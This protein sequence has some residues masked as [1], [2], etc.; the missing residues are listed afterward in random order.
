MN[1][2]LKIFLA[3]GAS[4][5]TLGLASFLSPAPSVARSVL[6]SAV[7]TGW[8][9]GPSVDGYGTIIHTTDGGATWV[10][11]GSAAQ[12]PDVYLHGVRAIDAHN[13]WVVGDE[14]DGYGVIL[15]TTDGG[16][17]WVRQGSPA[18]IP[19]ADLY[20]VSA[21]DGNTAWV[22]GSEVVG[23]QSVILHTADGGNTW[24]RQG[25]GTVPPGDYGGVM[26]V[27]AQNVWV[28]GATL[29]KTGVIFR[30]TDGGT[31][32]VQQGQ[33]LDELN[34]HWLIS[35]YA[36]DTDTA[37]A[38]GHDTTIHTS[39]SGTT[40]ITQTL[41]GVGEVDVNDVFAVDRNTAW[42][43]TDFGGI[44]FSQNGGTTWT[45]QTVPPGVEG[46]YLIRISAIDAQTAW[47]IG[48]A[49]SFPPDGVV[50]HTEDG[51]NTW[52]E[53][54]TPVT[55]T[56]SGVSFARPGVYFLPLILKNH[57]PA[58][59]LV[60]E[61]IVAEANQVQVVIKNQGDQ[62]V[63]DDEA[64]EFW[65]DLYINP[66]PVPDRVNQTWPYVAD[67]GAAWGITWSGSPYT[68]ADPARQ[69][70]PLEPGEVFTLTTEGDYWWQPGD[71]ISWPLTLGNAVYAQVDSAGASYG[72]VLENHEITG[73]PYNNVS[74]E[75]NVAGLGSGAA[76][77]PEAPEREISQTALPPRP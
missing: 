49:M 22:V 32:W 26:A 74:A 1:N 21:I 70:L 25:Q 39:D 14:S 13:A 51:G 36:V 38:V 77:P 56:W 46:Y 19:V 2:K 18:Q 76:P 4:I 20:R 44:Y 35:I 59:D 65:V 16:T 69:A 29:D 34:G 24:T 12:I 68:P 58:P 45:K 48:P 54:S 66:N 33:S 37:W 67:E 52:V 5:A 71:G 64:H 60:V 11:Q 47:V 31:T 61:R 9:V 17:T 6:S 50:L 55:T 23:S 72:A 15:R 53:Q 30:T 43:V 73:G 41:P 28:V 57:S 62:S 8:V 75:F 40:W 63:P 3:L 10:R 27:D 42:T 7:A